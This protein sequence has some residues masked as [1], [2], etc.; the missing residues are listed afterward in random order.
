MRSIVVDTA[1][2][3][4]RLVGKIHRLVHY[5]DDNAILVGNSNQKKIGW[6]G[7]RWYFQIEMKL[8]VVLCIEHDVEL[9]TMTV[10][11]IKPR[12]IVKYDDKAKHFMNLSFGRK[13]KKE[14]EVSR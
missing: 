14:V 5:T 1:T 10:H 12:S 9:R 4:M 3:C 2:G 13:G 11:N 7:R 8:K 6:I